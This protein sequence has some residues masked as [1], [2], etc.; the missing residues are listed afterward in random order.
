MEDNVEER[1]K[2]LEGIQCWACLDSGFLHEWVDGA[3]CMKYEEAVE[4]GVVSE[5]KPQ[6]RLMKCDHGKDRGF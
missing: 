5:E 4:P 3:W 6:I 2:G 1:I